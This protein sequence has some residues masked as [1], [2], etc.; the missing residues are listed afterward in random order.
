LREDAV[1]FRTLFPVALLVNILVSL[2]DLRA[3]GTEAPAPSDIAKLVD[4]LGHRDFR[5]R[6]TATRHLS[7]LGVD[8]LPALLKLRDHPDPEVR[9]R[10]VEVV[11]PLESAARVAPK[12]IRFRLK[13]RPVAEAL[14]ELTRQ[15]GYKIEPWPPGA[16]AAPAPGGVQ[17]VY[18]F[19]V[20]D[21]PFWQALDNVCETAG[22]AVQHNWGDERIRVGVQETRT[23]YIHHD[24]L[25]RIVA[26]GIQ[27]HRGIQ[28]GQVARQAM[29]PGQRTENCYFSLSVAAEPRLPLLGFG[30]VRLAAA[31]DDQSGSLIAIE[32]QAMHAGQFHHLYRQGLS[33]QTQVN[34]AP[35]SRDARFLKHIKGS[36][37][38]TLLAEQKPLI[39]INDVLKA[40]GKKFK[41]DGTNLDIEDVTLTPE[42]IYHV[43]LTLADTRKDANPNDYTWI[44]TVYQ[45]VELLDAKGNK[46]VSHGNNWS[47]TTPTS[48]QGTFMFGEPGNGAIGPPAKFIYHTWVTIQHQ[49]Q[50]EFKNL[51]L[52]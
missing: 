52:P 13:Q 22:M 7:A 50:F 12:R 9:R 42:K 1:V 11:G 29:V 26:E 6:D 38:V 25:F 27:Q 49:V 34:L 39:V 48:L 23:P 45:R 37:P 40:K 33:Q 15:S 35:P 32:H 5:V 24:G 28:F 2:S 44:N 14:T 41:A 47:N 19:E 4:Q 18:N 17:Q 51:P 36:L 20:D 10:L 43:K 30:Q 3:N 31:V 8:S 46:Y 21:Q 16:A